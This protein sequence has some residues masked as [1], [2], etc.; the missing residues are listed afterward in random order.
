MFVDCFGTELEPPA[1]ELILELNAARIA[2]VAQSGKDSYHYPSFLE[3]VEKYHRN[4]CILLESLAC[5][6][7][8]RLKGQLQFVWRGALNEAPSKLHAAKNELIYEIVMSLWT[9]ALLRFRQA[10]SIIHSGGAGAPK[11]AA[12]LF[13]EAASITQYVRLDCCAV[14][15]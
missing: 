15:C 14:L 1:L 12:K 5:Q 8:V 6:P 2:I 13:M 7:V 11:D 10:V 3:L 4:L 9:A